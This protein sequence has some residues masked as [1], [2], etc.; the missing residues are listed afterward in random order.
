MDNIAILGIEQCVLSGLADMFS[1]NV[2]MT[3]PEPLLQEIAAETEDAQAERKR[4]NHKLGVLE[5][6]LKTLNRLNRQKSAGQR[7]P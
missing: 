3:V 5:A 7:F 4:L 1:P 6:G 2:V